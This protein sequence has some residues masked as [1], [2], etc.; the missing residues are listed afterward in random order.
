MLTANGPFNATLFLSMLSMVSGA[1][2]VFPSTNLGVTST[3]SHLIGAYII[4]VPVLLRYGFV[5]TFA[6]SKISLTDWEISGPIPSPSI[7]LTA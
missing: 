5:R 1:M 6:A 7:K 4:S 2:T 3:G